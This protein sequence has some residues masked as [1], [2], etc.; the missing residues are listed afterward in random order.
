MRRTPHDPTVDIR[1]VSDGTAGTI[2]SNVVERKGVDEAWGF[3]G[4]VGK[5]VLTPRAFDGPRADLGEVPE[6]N[7]NTIVFIV[8]EGKEVDE[9]GDLSS[10]S[11]APKK[12]IDGE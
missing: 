1:E 2:V 8:V 5:D 3:E 12:G 10:Q 6:G 4:T 7:A 9:I 11:H